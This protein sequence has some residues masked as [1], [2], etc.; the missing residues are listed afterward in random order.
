MRFNRNIGFL[1]LANLASLIFTSELSIGSDDILSLN[2]ALI[3]ITAGI[4]ILID[5]NII[6]LPSGQVFGLGGASIPDRR[7][8]CLSWSSWD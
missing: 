1:L 2:L 6:I 7:F 8:P 5:R 3:A 4:F